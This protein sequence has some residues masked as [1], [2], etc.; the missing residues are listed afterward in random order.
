M[1]SWISYKSTP[2]QY[3]TQSRKREKN[4]RRD[5]DLW[6]LGTEN[7]TLLSLSAGKIKSNYP[8]LCVKV[9]IS[10]PKSNKSLSPSFSLALTLHILR[11]LLRRERLAASPMPSGLDEKLTD[12]S[13]SKGEVCETKDN[14]LITITRLQRLKNRFRT[15]IA[16]DHD[17]LLTLFLCLF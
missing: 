6:D 2:F 13:D 16:A 10:I 7:E 3:Q 14:G 9:S 11:L 17:V 5:G 8:L 1:P 4:I 15:F 12:A